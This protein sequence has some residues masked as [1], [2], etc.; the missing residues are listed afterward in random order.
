MTDLTTRIR[1]SGRSGEDKYHF[2]LRK[3]MSEYPLVQTPHVVRALAAHC[4]ALGSLMEYIDPE[5]Q[6]FGLRVHATPYETEFETWVVP[7]TEP[8]LSEEEEKMAEI[9]ALYGAINKAFA[10]IQNRVVSINQ[11]IAATLE[12]LNR[13]KDRDA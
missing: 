7:A 12:E 3:R 6:A 4:A 2:H 5:K 8:S 11:A 10:D 9:Q 13:S 1:P